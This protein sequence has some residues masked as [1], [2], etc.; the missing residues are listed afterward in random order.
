M[1]RLW[2]MDNRYIGVIINDIKNNS[3]KDITE[4]NKV[5]YK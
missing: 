1:C 4:K 3:F 5:L 2:E